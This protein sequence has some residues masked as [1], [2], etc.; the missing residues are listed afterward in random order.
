[1]S[2]QQPAPIS[3]VAAWFTLGALIAIVVF[4]FMDRQMVTLVAAPLARTLGLSNAQIGVVKGLGFTVF[5]LLA[6]YPITWLADRF[7]RRLVLGLC[8]V[9][10]AGGTAACG[11][12]QSFEQLFLAVVAIAAGEAGLTPLVLSVVPDLF[13]GRQRVTA[14]LLFYLS[15]IL[16]MALGLL[17]GSLAIS[18]L[19]AN[20]ADLPLALQSLEAWRLAFLIVSVPAPLFLILIAFMRLRTPA[21]AKT[22]VD[23]TAA[24]PSGMGGYLRDHGRTLALV[25][26]AVAM[27]TVASGGLFSWMPVAMDHAFGVTPAQNGLYLSGVVAFAVLG[28]VAVAG[29][30][31]RRVQP[32]LGKP[33]ALRIIGTVMAFAIPGAAL[34]PFVTAPWQAYVLAG[35]QGMFAA[36]IGSLLPHLLQDLAPASLRARVMGIYSMVTVTITGLSILATGAISDMLGAERGLLWA[37]TLIAIPA[38][39]IGV[40]L[41]RAAERPFQRTAEWAERT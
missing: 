8:V 39:I 15:T 9:V 6:T 19:T 2:T 16:G 12:A 36:I 1:M 35:I 3:P 11:F 18:G 38:W 32:R 37:L 17:F 22:A 29:L 34:L 24:A 14:N 5:S 25:L 40:V 13:H 10:W 30:W 27:F 33:A 31:M 4:A 23:E 28:G 21:P 20:H 7:D 26:G 41:F